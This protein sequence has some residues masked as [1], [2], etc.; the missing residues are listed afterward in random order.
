MFR[1]ED[2]KKTQTL[3]EF[4]SLLGYKP[5]SISY[6]LYKI[7]SE[8]KYSTFEIPKKNGDMRVINAPV[9]KVKH[10]QRRLANLLNEC[11]EEICESEHKKS[12]SHGFRKNHSIVTNAKKHRNKRHVFNVDL[13]DFFPSINFGRVRGFFIK[14]RHFNLDPK[15]ATVIAQI[16]CHNNELPQ[17]S[18]CSPVISNLIG[19]LLDIRMVNLAKKTKCT[20]SRYADDLT[21]STNQKEFPPKIAI[22]KS[23]CDWFV[24]KALKKEIEK[25][26]FLINDKKTSMQ[27][28]T[29]RQ[30]TTGLIVNEKV[31][32]R[33]EYYKKAR[34]MCYKL[35]KS[36]NFY[37]EGGLTQNDSGSDDTE[38][39]T[40]N[41][42]DGILSF[43]YQ[44]KRPHDF[45][46]LG[47]RRNDPT[48]VTKLYRQFLFY[49]HFFIN[50]IPL[51][52]CEGKTDNIYLTC[53][54]KQLAEGYNEL[55]QKIDNKIFFKIRFLNM[56]KNIRDVF[57][58]S[59]GTSGQEHLMGIY[60]EII[61]TFKGR[62]KCCPVIMLVDND[63]G[64][65]GI[66]KKIENS[67]GKKLTG[68]SFCHFTENLY[69]LSV[70]EKGKEIEDLFNR[71]TL[72]ERIDGKKFSR[73][74]DIN[75]RKEYGK[76]VFA[77]KVVKAKQNEINFNEFK[78][79]FDNFK[80]IIDDYS[81]KK[82]TKKKTTA[83]KVKKKTAKKKV[84]AK[85]KK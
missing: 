22:M 59:T 5:K 28:K 32:I 47:N 16:A 40:L 80:L 2:L 10:L 49:K 43:I 62:G 53:A 39:G 13:K 82:A 3:S 75:T 46:K 54:L 56:T 12:L 63:D 60:G 57:A 71:K 48:A 41:Q 79:I 66:K 44:I 24:G 58:I 11:F 18:P 23:E 55:A 72:E 15:V 33:K 74:K 61:K 1:L 85:K 76:N 17:G 42:L 30:M 8:N 14:N 29:S 78:E 6:I 52:I 51:V 50:E 21:F 25:V 67:N 38:L 84:V 70:P 26:G 34:S 9:E 27:F 83:N 81:G 19:H 20:Y 35:F 31:N 64:S 69:V 73:A 37:I 7:P 68:G 36:G 45:A 4:A 77:E 65:K